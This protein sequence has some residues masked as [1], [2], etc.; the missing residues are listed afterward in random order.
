[1]KGN[2]G[3][4]IPCSTA[5]AAKIMLS[6]PRAMKEL[7]VSLEVTGCTRVKWIAVFSGGTVT[8]NGSMYASLLWR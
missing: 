2:E 1:M 8:S 4:G 5:G 6:H 3:L 7:Y